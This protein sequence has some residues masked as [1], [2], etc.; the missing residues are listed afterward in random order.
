[1]LGSLAKGDPMKDDLTLSLSQ[2]LTKLAA[3]EES[4]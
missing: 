4:L 2:I 1:M 3:A